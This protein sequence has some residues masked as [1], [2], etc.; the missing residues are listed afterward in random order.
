M[1]GRI[2]SMLALF[3]FSAW[4]AH[5][6]HAP[7]DD[8]APH[9]LVEHSAFVENSQVENVREHATQDGEGKDNVE[10]QVANTHVLVFQNRN[11]GKFRETH[12]VQFQLL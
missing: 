6:V 11:F 8:H 4:I 5:A 1:G 2:E 10:Q 3:A 7:A 9:A 12:S